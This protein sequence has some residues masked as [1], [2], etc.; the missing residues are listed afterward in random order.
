[1]TGSPSPAPARQVAKRR[2]LHWLP[3]PG[4][5]VQLVRTPACHAGGR[6]FESRRSRRSPCKSAYCVVRLDAKIG[7]TTQRSF[8][9]GRNG[10]KRARNPV[11]G[12]RFQAVLAS[13]TPTADSASA[14]T[15]WPEVTTASLLAARSR[16]HIKP[17]PTPRPPA[18]RA[19]PRIGMRFDGPIL[20]TEIA[21]ARAARFRLLTS[22]ASARHSLGEAT[23]PRHDWSG[24]LHWKAMCLLDWPDRSQRKP[25]PS[26]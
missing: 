21:H 15:E 24:P 17:R 18:S 3:A 20:A 25:N 6:G 13:S 4:G 19:D 8:E 2:A 1:V 12:S 7:P 14:Y 10:P 26:A 9:A 5:V 11:P 23:A 16:R 22:T